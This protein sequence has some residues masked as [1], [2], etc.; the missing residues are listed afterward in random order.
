[1]LLMNAH[2]ASCRWPSLSEAPLVSV[3]IAAYNAERHIVETLESVRS[4]TYPHIEIIVVD[5][6]S[7]DGTADRVRAFGHGVRYV[8]Q[9]NS[10]TCSK[11]R[12]T[13]IACATGELITVLDADDLL[14][15]DKTARQVDFLRRH[16]DAGCVVVDYQNFGTS[17]PIGP[18][19]FQ[20]CPRLT[21]I[22]EQ[23]AAEG[24]K[25]AGRAKAEERGC[26]LSCDEAT[27][28]LAMENYTSS[29]LMIRREV[30]GEAGAYDESLRA[31]E[32]FELQYRI[33]T[34]F[35]TGV[36]PHVGLRRRLHESNMSADV[37]RMLQAKIASRSKLLA[38]ERNPAQR[39]LLRGAL[40]TLFLD[41]GYYETGR[42]N[43]RAL[44]AILTSVRYR[45]WPAATPARNL[46]RLLVS[47]FRMAS[48]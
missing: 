15:P 39:R 24:G 20:T 7:T 34:T 31:S 41:L 1:M 32:D 46:A 40:A 44:G 19:Q 27:S 25:A 8:H 33:S 23:K 4:Q 6:G 14:V 28:L 29:S 22:L 5:D 37:S 36:L 16:P 18:T 42:N 47:P 45:P 17:G 30:L 26:V 21:R 13:G 12:N 35:L 3:V 48:E 38:L 9:P 2:P 11:P 43:R 10:G